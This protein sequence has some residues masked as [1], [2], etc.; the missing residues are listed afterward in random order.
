MSN[1]AVSLN[2][3]IY[4]LTNQLW[5]I[6]LKLNKPAEEVLDPDLLRGLRAAADYIRHS[7]WVHKEHAEQLTG[8][9]VEQ[10]LMTHRLRRA[11]EMLEHALKERDNVQLSTEDQAFLE[12]IRNLAK[13]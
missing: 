5:E 7:L 11:S 1:D 13:S 8:K 12:K 2:D 10:I 9:T 4:D 3:N 6:H